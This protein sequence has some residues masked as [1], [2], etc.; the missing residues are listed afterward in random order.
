MEFIRQSAEQ[1]GAKPSHIKR[2]LFGLPRTDA[3]E[4]AKDGSET[5]E[6]SATSGLV[7]FSVSGEVVE[8]SGSKSLLE[9]AEDAGLN[10]KY[11]CR[12]GIC[13]ECKCQKTSGR[14]MN[15]MTGKIIP[16]EQ[17]QIQACISAPIGDLT[18]STW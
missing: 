7:S 4:V 16:D 1:L 5:V 9:L 8:S 2:E 17:D 15:M 11:G 13:H 14:V 18:V 3:V 6:Q 12:A 10:P